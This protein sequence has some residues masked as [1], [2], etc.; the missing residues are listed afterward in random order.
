MTTDAPDQSACFIAAPALF[1]VTRRVLARANCHYDK[2]MLTAVINPLYM[3]V[4]CFEAKMTGI[5]SQP[6]CRTVS[7]LDRKKTRLAY[8]VCEDMHSIQSPCA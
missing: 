1:R 6:C 5:R 3:R 8:A 7:M 4:F 2:R